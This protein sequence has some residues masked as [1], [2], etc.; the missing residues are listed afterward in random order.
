[1]YL[2]I[3]AFFIVAVS[4]NLS[5]QEA[6]PD[7]TRVLPQLL[8]KVPVAIYIQHGPNPNYPELNNTGR[9]PDSKYVWKHETTM[10]SPTKDL[11]VIKAGS[12][13]WYDSTGWKE[14]VIY[15]RKEFANRF[16]CPKGILKAGECFTFKENYRWGSNLYGGDALWYVLAKDDEGNIYKGMGLLETESELLKK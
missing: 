6:W 14:N 5:A 4:C 1:M 3:F 12:F 16:E 8:R 9:N 13:I 7:K 10:C 2:R 11:K 15:N